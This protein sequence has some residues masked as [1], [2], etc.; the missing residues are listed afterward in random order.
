MPSP[1]GGYGMPPKP[2]NYLVWAI[3]STI[4]C[5]LPFGI[6]SIVQAAKVD[7]LYTAGQYDESRRASESA[8]KWAIISAVTGLVVGVLYVLL[9]VVAGVAGVNYQ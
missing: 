2:D 7:G 3:L 5:C 9:V 4:L 8:K 1:G 6:V